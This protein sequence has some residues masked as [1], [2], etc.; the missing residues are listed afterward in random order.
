MQVAATGQA[1]DHQTDCTGSIFSSC[2][3]YGSRPLKYMG[4]HGPFRGSVTCDVEFFLK[5]VTWDSVTWTFLGDIIVSWNRHVT[6]GSPCQGP[7][8]IIT[9]CTRCT[10]L[11]L[12]EIREEIYTLPM[13]PDLTCPRSHWG[14]TTSWLNTFYIGN[15]QGKKVVCRK[16]NE[17]QPPEDICQLIA[18]T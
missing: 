3:H 17:L 13:T 2:K 14:E 7:H 16:T 6:L 1:P 11:C 5:I 10:A 18:F 15:V 8:H 4:R 9:R 12:Q